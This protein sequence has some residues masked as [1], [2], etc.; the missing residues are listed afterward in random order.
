MKLRVVSTREAKGAVESNFGD[1]AAG[2]E[3]DVCFTFTQKLA[4]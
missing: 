1:T 4:C 3:V 2:D